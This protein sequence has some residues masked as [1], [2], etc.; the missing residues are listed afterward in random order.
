MLVIS[1]RVE[2][3]DPKSKQ[4][5]TG[6]VA[7]SFCSENGFLYLWHVHVL[8]PTDFY[9]EKSDQATFPDEKTKLLV[10]QWC[11]KSLK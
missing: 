5:F 3:H 6:T 10:V 11:A 4:L 8:C 7:C 1:G 2:S 9:T